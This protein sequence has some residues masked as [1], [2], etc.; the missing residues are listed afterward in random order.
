M[1]NI[2]GYVGTRE[3]APILL[4]MIKA[5]EGI[6]GGFY[7]GLAVH[8]G[9]NLHFHKLRGDLE[10]LLKGTDAEKLVGNCGII[11]SRTPS[12]GPDLWAHPFHAE[13]KGAVQLCYVANGNYG[14]YADRKESY[15]AIADTIVAEGY[16]IPCKIRDGTDKYNR[17]S[18]G[19]YVH[20]SDV[21]CQLIYR[22][23]KRGVD[24]P[25]AMARAFADMPSEI[26]GLV[27]DREN[28]D[29]ISFCRINMPMFVG[30]DETGAYLAS[31]PT[32]FPAHIKKF[33]LL[34]A[35]SSGVICRD[36]YEVTDRPEFSEKVRGF[37]RKTVEK[38]A[39][40][41]LDLL[42]EGEKDYEDM[43]MAVKKILPKNELVQT[44]PIIYL[45]LH[46]LLISGK[47]VM[48]QRTKTV[49][50]Q[51]APATKFSLP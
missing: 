2:A 14:R 34:P 19:D 48:C 33:T 15:N 49:A 42:A 8:D 39:G 30:F 20:V 22:Y 41:I 10:K 5:Q 27:I 31:T 4:Q 44:P 25:N 12:G 23:K 16:D 32:A 37:N 29:R 40:I 7:T 1:C 3:A 17:L 50:G 24:T 26:V 45:A 9:E 35:L 38:A 47:A 18:S 36:R 21:M 43:R 11:H 28:P 6:D 13:E 51:T 46:E